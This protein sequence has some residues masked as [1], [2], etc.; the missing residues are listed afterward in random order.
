MF[1][2]V[3]ETAQLVGKNRGVTTLAIILRGD[4]PINDL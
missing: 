2:G 3:T 4:N 1:R